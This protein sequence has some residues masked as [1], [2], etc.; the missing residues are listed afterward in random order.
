MSA[1]PASSEA[2]KSV[3][4]T[5]RILRLDLEKKQLREALQ[6]NAAMLEELN[7]ELAAVAH[8]KREWTHRQSQFE[9]ERKVISSK[10]AKARQDL[11]ADAKALFDDIYLV[12]FAPTLRRLRTAVAPPSHRRKGK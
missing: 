7:V 4:R 5:Q 9:V 12:D 6:I 10:E 1:A 2:V 8:M 3:N 11:E